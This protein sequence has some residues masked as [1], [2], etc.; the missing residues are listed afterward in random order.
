MQV[1][2]FLERGLYIP[3]VDDAG[4]RA[5]TISTWEIYFSPLNAS[6]ARTTAGVT[7]RSRL[8]EGN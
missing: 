3:V 2:K 6:M 4:T 8:S 5:R 1:D 7:R